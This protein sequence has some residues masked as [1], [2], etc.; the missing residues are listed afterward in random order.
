[1]S[2]YEYWKIICSKAISKIN[3]SDP[4]NDEYS[5]SRK[6]IKFSKQFNNFKQ[7]QYHSVNHHHPCIL[8]LFVYQEQYKEFFLMFFTYKTTNDKS[9]ANCIFDM[10][11]S[12][13]SWN[14]FLQVYIYIKSTR[15]DVY[16]RRKNFKWRYKLFIYRSSTMF[17]SIR[18]DFEFSLLTFCLIMFETRSIALTSG[19]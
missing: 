19:L 13:Y 4:K 5:I 14:N 2:R 16:N 8:F 3:G 12:I 15:A 18:C 11:F 1:M 7:Y 6:F 17:S 9:I 10:K